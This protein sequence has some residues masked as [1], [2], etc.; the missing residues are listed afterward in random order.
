MIVPLILQGR[1]C[2]SARCNGLISADM[3]QLSSALI[4]LI[5]N[6]QIML[7][8]SSKLKTLTFMVLFT[9]NVMHIW[10]SVG[11]LLVLFFGKYSPWAHSHT[12]IPATL[13]FWRNSNQDIGCLNLKTA[14]NT[15][16]FIKAVYVL[17]KRG[18]CM[19]PILVFL[20]LLERKLLL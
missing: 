5:L 15:C 9:C 11:G 20:G 8:L 3:C 18:E 7:A 17:K 19:L 10:K 2:G 16:M 14:L 6:S 13:R 12:W 4:C 1:T